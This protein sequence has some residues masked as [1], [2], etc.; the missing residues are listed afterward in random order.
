M[1]LSVRLTRVM[2]Y[3]LLV[4]EGQYISLI[5]EQELVQ[6]S[7]NFDQCAPT[8]THTALVWVAKYVDGCTKTFCN[9]FLV[10]IRLKQYNSFA[11]NKSLHSY[12]ENSVSNQTI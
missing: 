8:H 7:Q 4:C 11:I 3:N 9:L 1:R 10:Y 6:L 12:F 5:V 2:T